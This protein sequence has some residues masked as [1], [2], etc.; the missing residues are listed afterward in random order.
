V[1]T[2]TVPPSRR[3]T[4]VLRPYVAPVLLV[5]LV[6]VLTGC[7]A[8]DETAS[9]A[10]PGSGSA[11]LSTAADPHALP[12]PGAPL[13]FDQLLRLDEAARQRYQ[14]AR[15]VLVDRCLEAAGF[16][17][18]KA[19]PI[20]PAGYEVRQG[21]NN[22]SNITDPAHGY[23]SVASA[24]TRAAWAEQH[25][26]DTWLELHPPSEAY[27]RVQ[28]GTDKPG[29]GGT[30]IGCEGK[31]QRAI[32][33]QDLSAQERLTTF[34]KPVVNQAWAEATTDPDVV[35]AQARWSACLARA[36]Y[37]F[38]TTW[39]VQSSPR[40]GSAGSRDWE[41]RLA[42]A[43]VA[44]QWSSHL[45]AVWDRVMTGVEERA[46]DAQ[47]EVIE[48]LQDDQRHEIEVVDQVLDRGAVE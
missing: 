32:S 33:G 7:T 13:P 34:L 3:T 45:S 18:V 4:R 36:G 25:A 11:I 30:D 5:L 46:I 37:D 26:Y 8:S 1:S 27:R 28:Y 29:H 38:D 2:P 31:A 39:A 44:C 22:V 15:Q 42:H 41:V 19:P 48:A 43:D 17:P 35:A 47:A 12:P 24:L 9:T 20:P 40:L 21:G 6:L 23:G 10:P 14:Q 16:T